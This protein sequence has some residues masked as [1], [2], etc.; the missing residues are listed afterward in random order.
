MTS[1]SISQAGVTTGQGTRSHAEKSTWPT[2]RRSAGELRAFRQDEVS[3]LV[4]GD[5]NGDGAADFSLV[6]MA[7]ADADLGFESFL[8]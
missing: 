8:L 7:G 2:C 4:E 1:E 5:M 3:R 6:A